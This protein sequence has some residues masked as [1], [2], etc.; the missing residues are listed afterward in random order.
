MAKKEN[1]PK[2]DSLI[3]EG[4]KYNTYL[5]ERYKARKPWAEKDLSK[6]YAFI[7]G[8]IGDIEVKAGQEVAEKDALLT[9]EAMKMR[10]IIQSPA[11]GVV[12]EIHVKS[13]ENVVKSQLLVEFE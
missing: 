7:S 11:D 5:T 3:V 1:K 6:V 9:L 4:V 8:T 2:Y 12:K 13:G 10:N